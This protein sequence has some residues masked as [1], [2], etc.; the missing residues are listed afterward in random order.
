MFYFLTLRSTSQKEA[1]AN[2]VAYGGILLPL[3]MR[4]I[5]FVNIIL[6]TGDLFM[7]TCSIIILTFKILHGNIFILDADI[8]IWQDTITMLHVNKFILHVGGRR[9]P[10]K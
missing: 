2:E 8:V 4:Y 10:P 3:H 5:H 1:V 6:L 9:V 7:S